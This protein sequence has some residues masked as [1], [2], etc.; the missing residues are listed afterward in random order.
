MV[1]IAITAPSALVRGSVIMAAADTD[2]INVFCVWCSSLIMSEYCENCKHSKHCKH[3]RQRYI[4]A[5]AGGKGSCEDGG[6]RRDL[7]AYSTALGVVL[8]A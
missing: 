1:T 5:S 8:C 6:H 7:C 4:L 2:A 3:S